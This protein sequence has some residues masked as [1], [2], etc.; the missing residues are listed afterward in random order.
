[1]K[2]FNIEYKLIMN[3]IAWGNFCVLNIMIDN[4]N[5]IVLA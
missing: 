1:M 3:V 5:D 2:G 4:A